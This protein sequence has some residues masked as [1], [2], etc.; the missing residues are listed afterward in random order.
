[1]HETRIVHHDFVSHIDRYVIV[2]KCKLGYVVGLSV[3]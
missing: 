2:L 3:P 1:M